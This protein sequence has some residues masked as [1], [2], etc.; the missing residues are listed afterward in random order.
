MMEQVKPIAVIKRGSL[1]TAAKRALQK[2]GYIVV[3]SEDLECLRLVVGGAIP[4]NAS[5]VFHHA[6]LALKDSYAGEK[7]GKSLAAALADETQPLP[8]QP[9]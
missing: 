3:E 8:H 1:A 6:M 5:T 7:F 9:T 4:L 2:G